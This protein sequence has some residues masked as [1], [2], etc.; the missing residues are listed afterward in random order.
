M[1]E[2]TADLR[3]L[4][5]LIMATPANTEEEADPEFLTQRSNAPRYQTSMPMIMEKDD[6]EECRALDYDGCDSPGH[7]GDT[8]YPDG[9]N[10]SDDFERMM[11]DSTQEMLT[12]EQF[13]DDLKAKLKKQYKKVER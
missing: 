9:T 3:E 2:L 8:A 1:S 11:Q 13:R 10:I 7:V 4:R 6:L 5:R 12:W